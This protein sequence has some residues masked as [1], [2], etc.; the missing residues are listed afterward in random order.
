MKRILIATV[1]SLATAGSVSAMTSTTT[2]SN[3]AAV[4]ANH[5]LPSASFDNLTADQAARIEG[6]LTG[7]KDFLDSELRQ[8]LNT[9]LA[10]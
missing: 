4:Q 3:A 8:R 5:I 1:L 9:A 10:S 6:L 2:L 7:G